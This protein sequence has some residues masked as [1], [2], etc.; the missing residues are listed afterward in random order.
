[1]LK[2]N[3]I[4]CLPSGGQEFYCLDTKNENLDQMKIKV[5]SQLI[6]Y[7]FFLLELIIIIVFLAKTSFALEINKLFACQDFDFNTRVNFALDLALKKYDGQK[8]WLIYSVDSIYSMKDIKRMQETGNT[9]LTLEQIIFE[10]ICPNDNRTKEQEIQRKVASINQIKPQL[11]DKN[12]PDYFKLAI[13]LDYSLESG[14]PCLYHIFLQ[15]MD[16]PFFKEIRPIF[17]LGEGVASTSL[18]WLKYQFHK[19]TYSKLQQQ[20]IASIGAHKCSKQVVEFQKHIILGNYS[21]SLK[22][23]AIHWLGRHNS[24]ETINL[25]TY[26]A[27]KHKDI[28]LRKKS[29]FAL[30]QLKTRDAFAI[31]SILARKEKNQEVR[32]TAIFWLSQLPCEDATEV[33]NG[34]L[35]NENNLKIKEYTLFAISQLPERKATPILSRIAQT[36]P[37]SRIRKRAMFWL[38]QTKDQRM[39]DFFLDL[40]NDEKQQN[41]MINLGVDSKNIE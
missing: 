6:L 11:E 18:D 2:N 40:A 8:I 33:L 17:W 25:L 10:K 24:H 7:F 19:T 26:L 29:I 28:R 37:D 30:S 41:T 1:L 35:M 22:N 21:L 9:N 31:I 16:Q 4:F 20:M 34:I 27:L 13:I 5:K 39:L 3:F 32:Q 12:R 36:S 23:E 15:R 14:N 38:D